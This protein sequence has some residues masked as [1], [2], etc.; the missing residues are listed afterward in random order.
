MGDKGMKAHAMVAI[1]LPDLRGGG[2]ERVCLNLANN[3]V[4]RGISVDMVLMQ[5]IGEL[6]PLLDSRVNVVDL[7]VRRARGVAMP[8]IRYLR[9]AS[10]DS[11]LANMWPLT[12][13]SALARAWS[14][15][16]MR[17]VLVEHTTL[18]KSEIR[19]SPLHFLVLRMSMRILA[20]LADARVTVSKGVAEDLAKITGLC[21]DQFSTIYNPIVQD[22]DRPL[23]PESL[24]GGDPSPIPVILNVGTLKAQK[25]QAT[26]LRAFSILVSEMDAKLMILGEG[27]L[28]ADL[29]ALAVE[30]GIA[31]RVSMPGFTTDP[32]QAY[33]S[34][35]LFVLSSAWEGFGNV[36]VEALYHGVPVVST[37]C[38]SGPSEILDGGR[39]GSLVPIRDPQAIAIAMRDALS[40]AHDHEAL[41]RRAHDFSVDKAA[42]AYLD[43]L[44]PG[45]RQSDRF[46]PLKVSEQITAKSTSTLSTGK[47]FE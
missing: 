45:W 37:D 46:T 24:K 12:I 6:L 30:L 34:A 3:F 14:G 44:L 26:L 9:R 10:P 17:L 25:D 29:E 47:V 28:R 38:P 1:L 31:D 4:A 22:Q 41:K 13:I 16:A 35:S 8:L 18:S 15:L 40:R 42:D 21:R 32:S 2:A 7:R 23:N 5:N 43:L 27:E 39:F 19:W 33:N 11:L 20:P 36:I